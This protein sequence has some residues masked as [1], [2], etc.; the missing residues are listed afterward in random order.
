MPDRPTLPSELSTPEVMS[1]S[2]RRKLAASFSQHLAS[3]RG[4]Q[5]A[6]ILQ[7]SP[8]AMA[9][10][11]QSTSSEQISTPCTQA[12]LT[13]QKM[14]PTSVQTNP[15]ST[16]P[17]A[18]TS[19]TASVSQTNPTS[20]SQNLSAPSQSAVSVSQP[21]LQTDS[22]IT[23]IP[24][25]TSITTTSMAQCSTSVETDAKSV[26]SK[27]SHSYYISWFCLSYI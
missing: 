6:T 3:T 7:A 19:L 26:P 21:S 4:P 1:C 2:H 13:N 10:M 17:T 18:T 25:P 9:K 22:V 11:H 23:P 20:G 8:Q 24:S 5:V 16:T 12:A 27:H 15:S 14:T